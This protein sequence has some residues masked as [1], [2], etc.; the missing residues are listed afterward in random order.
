MTMTPA[1]PE[2]ADPASPWYLVF[3]KPR[4]EYVAQFNLVQQGFEVYL[5]L[6]KTWPTGRKAQA[7]LPAGA[8]AGD[9]AVFEPLF[10]RYV[11][12]KPGNARQSIAAARSTRGVSSLVSFGF[13]PALVQPDT[14]ALIRAS[15]QERNQLDLAQ[16]S[17]FQPGASVRLRG[18]GLNGLQGLVQSVS[19]KRVTLLLELLGR[20]QV[21]S[22]EH[23]QIEMN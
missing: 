7:G 3:T 23:H 5:P 11:F 21:L 17:P 18:E 14:M 12:F 19:A 13:E 20:E 1:E 8:A 22:V 9:Q 15:E 4:Q 2:H 10:A 6:F 16:I